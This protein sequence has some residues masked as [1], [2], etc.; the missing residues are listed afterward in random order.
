M[1]LKPIATHKL[2]HQKLY[3]DMAE[4]AELEPMS[5][6]EPRCP[7][8]L[9]KEERKVWRYYKSILKTYGLFS[10]ANAPLLELL[11]RLT[12]EV[13]DFRKKSDGHYMVR[14]PNDREKWIVNPYWGALRRLEDKIMNCLKELGLSSMG[15]ARIGQLS[16]RKK[17]ETDGYFED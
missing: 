11:S 6:L 2:N 7:Q 12:A 15:M 14:D 16:V 13:Q 17:K 1:N 9:T 10:I 4:R 8:G 3:G 5:E